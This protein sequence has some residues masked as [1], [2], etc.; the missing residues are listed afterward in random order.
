MSV[1][2]L[3]TWIEINK[4]SA[5]RNVKI[6]RS[7]VSAKTEIW[8][9]VK[10]NA[11]GHG[12]TAFSKIAD[13]VGIDGFCV[14]S[15]KEGSKLRENGIVKPILVLGPTLP[16]LY[17]EAQ[18]NKV[19]VTV[20]NK[21]ALK[22][23]LKSPK[24]P[25]FHLKI[26]SGMHRQGFYPEEIPK[27]ISSLKK[28]K[29][30]FRGVYTHFCSAKDINYPTYTELQFK[31]FNKVLAVLEKAGFNNLVKHVAATG[32]TL[33]NKKYHL[34]AVRIGIGFYGLWPSKELNIQFSEIKLQP[35][36]SWHAFVSE[37]KK[38][39]KG[40]YI[41]YDLVERAAKDSKIA[42]LPIGYWHGFPRALSSI[43]HVLISGKLARVLGRVSMDLVVVDVA[44]I[45][46]RVGDEA[47][48]IGR[49]GKVEITASD[50]AGQV[51]TSHYELITR[52]N[53]LIERIV[54]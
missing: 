24:K 7:L 22:D 13:D 36:F 25:D 20:S 16:A 39:R 35:V 46:C 38:I 52:V 6:F 49:Q 8:A 44:G 34:D 14:D 23:Y 26:D 50:V 53:P 29:N 37:V 12:L 2:H 3:K 32:G 45:K 1:K 27:I 43:G 15:V 28:V 4:K 33:I 30:K 47:V 17:K 54:T 19:T 10:S 31:N 9:V 40:D 48:I 51:G 42:V 21:D 5:I 18:D 41:G 11:Y